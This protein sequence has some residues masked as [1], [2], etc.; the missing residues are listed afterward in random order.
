MD[1]TL[2]DKARSMMAQS[3]LRG[4]SWG[5]VFKAASY[6]RNR[7]PVANQPKT[8]HELWTDRMPSIA[9]FRS[10]GFKVYSPLDKGQR[11]GKLGEV[12][13]ARVLIGYS[14]ESPSYRVWDPVKG[15]VLNVGGADFDEDVEPGWWKGLGEV[16]AVI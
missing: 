5:E 1:R 10:F 3:G 14:K 16:G 8:P 4:G 13:R 11:G 12:R 9:S 15:K 6:I 7:G 2:Q